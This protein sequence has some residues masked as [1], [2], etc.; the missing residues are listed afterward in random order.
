M[1]YSSDSMAEAYSDA[2]NYVECNRIAVEEMHRQVGDLVVDNEGVARRGLIIRL[3]VLPN[4]ISGTKDTIRFIAKRISK[5]T[6]LSIMSQYY[7]TFRACNYREL[8]SGV[9]KKEYLGIV[10]EAKDM[11]LDNG[12]V[13]EIPAEVDT[14]YAGTSIRPHKP[15]G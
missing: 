10:D 7:P 13:Q 11:G 6:F 3:L 15:V 2:V 4:D 12:W 5:G 9:T 1:R 14:K 8:S